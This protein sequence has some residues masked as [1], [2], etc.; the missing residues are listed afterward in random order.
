MELRNNYIELSYA[1]VVVEEHLLA[2]TYE[3][4]YEGTD[5][6]WLESF[7][8]MPY[9][10]PSSSEFVRSKPYDYDMDGYKANVWAGAF[11]LL[12][13]WLKT[14]NLETSVEIE[15]DSEA[16]KLYIKE[17]TI[18]DI[19]ELYNMLLLDK[20]LHKDLAFLD[21]VGLVHAYVDT[22]KHRESLD[23]LYAD[24]K[25]YAEKELGGLAKFV[26]SPYYPSLLELDLEPDFEKFIETNK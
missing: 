18:I 3:Q 15:Q 6:D 23:A 13:Y 12:N 5:N 10:S 16:I 26:G 2:L 7:S 20:Q 11:Q 4:D 17:G 25:T 9:L 19:D 8:D 22:T 21:V 24:I 14:N 1:S